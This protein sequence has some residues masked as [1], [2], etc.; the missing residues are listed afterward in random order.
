MND[1]ARASPSLRDSGW[2]YREDDTI[3]WKSNIN[4]V[5]VHYNLW[6]QDMR[7]RLES[8]L[9]RNRGFTAGPRYMD[10]M[11]G[12]PLS[13]PEARAVAEYNE[14]VKF[15]IFILY[16]L[17]ANQYQ[18]NYG[19]YPNDTID[20]SAMM[21]WARCLSE[22]FAAFSGLP[23]AEG[24]STNIGFLGWNR[25]LHPYAYSAVLELGHFEYLKDVPGYTGK[26]LDY[27]PAELAQFNADVSTRSGVRR[28]SVWTKNKYFPLYVSQY[29]INN[30]LIPP[31]GE[32]V[33]LP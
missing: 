3:Y 21:P 2:T 10:Y 4:G 24:I 32:S 30:A 23:L 12:A 18:W 7:K 22:R 27:C 25:E 33:G 28:Y 26:E 17:M 6:N 19:Y 1:T 11:G 16:H 31:A 14:Q 20:D 5:D 15:N 13:E 8:W 9:G 29:L